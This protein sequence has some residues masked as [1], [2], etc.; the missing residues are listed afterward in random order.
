M[1]NRATDKKEF[2]VEKET[3][4]RDHKCDCKILKKQNIP[5]MYACTIKLHTREDNK[6][7]YTNFTE[8]ITHHNSFVK[9]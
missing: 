9:F 7:F 4:Q 5:Q 3:Y 6:S 8:M 2:R 1:G